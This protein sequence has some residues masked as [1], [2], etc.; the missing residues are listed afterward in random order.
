MKAYPPLCRRRGGLAGG[1]AKTR[2]PDR[3]VDNP[4]SSHKGLWGIFWGN[5]LEPPLTRDASS[6]AYSS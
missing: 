2:H 1:L 4:L 5:A 6:P 3:V